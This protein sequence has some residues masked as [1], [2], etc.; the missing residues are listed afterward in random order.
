MVELSADGVRTPHCP[1]CSTV[2]VHQQTGLAGWSCPEG[3]GV[4]ATLSVV[5]SE[6]SGDTIAELWDRSDE[7]MPSGRDC[8]FCKKPMMPVEASIANSADPATAA[9][10]VRLDI[11]R[12]DQLIWFDPGEL[13]ALPH[14]SATGPGEQ[15]PIIVNHWADAADHLPDWSVSAVISDIRRNTDTEPDED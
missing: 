8:P 1:I 7:V 11:C 6:V 14:P 10:P 4:A 3:H 15:P 2:L 13:D 5:R 12:L 9:A